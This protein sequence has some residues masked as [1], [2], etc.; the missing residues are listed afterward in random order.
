M[1]GCMA[2]VTSCTVF[3]KLMIVVWV[4]HTKTNDKDRNEET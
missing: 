1:T 2:E 3:C 4:N